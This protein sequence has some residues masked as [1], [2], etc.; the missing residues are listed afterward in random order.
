MDMLESPEEI[1]YFQYVDSRD[2]LDA[3][4]AAQNHFICYKASNELEE[5]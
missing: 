5:K 3:Q 2:W 4:K 1:K